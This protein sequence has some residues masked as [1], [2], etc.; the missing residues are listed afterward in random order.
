[1]QPLPEDI[2]PAMQGIIPSLVV[3]CD[4]DGTPNITSISQ[5]YYVD[6]YHVA[7]S[8]Q[9]F[10]KTHRNI[11]EN[12]NAC[13]CLINHQTNELWNIDIQYSH[14][15]TDG[16]VFEQ[17]DMQL[18]AIASMSGMS[19]IFNLRAADIYKVKSFKKYSSK[20]KETTY[21]NSDI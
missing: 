21:F 12:L 8:F 7:L 17:M 1:M 19:D 3:T 10:N 13:V 11:R 9:F 6:P 15:E 14:S 4:L 16:P 2:N 5:V 18:E 20:T